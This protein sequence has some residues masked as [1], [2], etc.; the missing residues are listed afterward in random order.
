MAD[1]REQSGASVRPD[2]QLTMEKM[3]PIGIKV[4]EMILSAEVD[5]KLTRRY[6]ELGSFEFV[7]EKGRFPM[8]TIAKD[9]EHEFVGA[10]NLADPQN[11]NIPLLNYFLNL[12]GGSEE[13]YSV[14]AEGILDKGISF[15][16]DHITGVPSTGP[17]VG[18]EL[19]TLVGKPYYEIIEKAGE[20][21][22][23]KFNLRK[24][25]YGEQQPEKGQKALIVDDLI[26]RKQTKDDAE[27]EMLAGGFEVAGH[28]V[29][30]DREEGGVD[31]MQEEGR[32]IVA[33]ITA[34]E[35]F[36]VALIRGA[37][38]EEVFD[39]IMKNINDGKRKSVQKIREGEYQAI[40]HLPIPPIGHA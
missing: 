29:V 17:H 28:A 36:A 27:K 35:L 15:P 26:T 5:G 8:L 24:F 12:R 23:R 13:N 21:T 32:K 30:V 1:L 7:A 40:K 34:T 20:G 4:A 31:E 11:P 9:P 6:G 10:A 33:A 18:K 14:M 2:V 37:V 38:R 19:A 39:K 25:Q 16:Y 22:G 3:S